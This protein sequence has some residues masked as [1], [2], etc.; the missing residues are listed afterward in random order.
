MTKKVKAGF[1]RIP[2]S[3]TKSKPR[4]NLQGKKERERK[5]NTYIYPYEMKIKIFNKIKTSTKK[6]LWKHPSCD[7]I[8]TKCVPSL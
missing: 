6:L 5:S 1:S 7:Y 2:I 8:I 4:Y 3:Q